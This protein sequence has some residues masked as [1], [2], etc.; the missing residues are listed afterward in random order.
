M[1]EKKS[2]KLTG[3]NKQEKKIIPEVGKEKQIK[4]LLVTYNKLEKKSVSEGRRI[5][6]KLRRLGYYLSKQE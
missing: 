5:R 6:R 3:E 4:E 2:N 1:K